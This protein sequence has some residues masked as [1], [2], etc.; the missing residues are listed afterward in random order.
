M[1]GQN[2]QNGQN[3][4]YQDNTANVP[5]QYPP[6]SSGNGSGKANG[7]Q[8]ASL[9][10]GIASICLSCCCYGVPSIILGIIGTICAVMGNKENKHGVGTAGLVCSIIGIVASI[11]ITIASI[12]LGVGLGL[13]EELM[14]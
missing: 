8:I 12:F 9:I 13:F 5:Y 4:S 1:D 6:N 3:N 7:M 10:L 2:F 11:F 14:Y